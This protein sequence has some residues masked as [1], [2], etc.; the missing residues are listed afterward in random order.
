MLREPGSVY[1]PRRTGALRKVKSF[2]DAEARI[3]GYTAGTGKHAGRLGAYE[4]VL[5]KGSRAKFRIGTG[6]SDAEREQPLPV[7]TVVTVKFQ[8]LTDDGVPRFPALVGPRD[9]E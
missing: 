7:G 8:E 6:I 9:Y 3:T 4:A 1:E 2:Q 5:L